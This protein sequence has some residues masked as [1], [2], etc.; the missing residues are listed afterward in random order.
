MGNVAFEG[1]LLLF[2]ADNPRY[3]YAQLEDDG[4]ITEIAEKRVISPYAI[5]GGHYIATPD[6]LDQATQAVLS[7]P[8]FSSHNEL[9]ITDMY[10][11]LLELGGKVVGVT[12]ERPDEFVHFGSPEELQ[13]YQALKA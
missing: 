2:K 9:Y 4:T 6:I 13:A 5:A 8:T 12:V 11:K 3:G 7:D 10:T 1:A